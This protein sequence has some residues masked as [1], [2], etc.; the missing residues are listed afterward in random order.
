MS[1]E[2]ECKKMTNEECKSCEYCCSAYAQ[3]GYKFLTCKFPPYKGKWIAEIS[4]CP[5]LLKGVQMERIR[6]IEL[7]HQA[8]D[9][10][11]N[12]PMIDFTATLAD[13]LLDNGVIV[14]PVKVGDTVYEI[15]RRR[16]LRQRKVVEILIAE[17]PS[18]VVGGDIYS[19]ERYH[20]SLF[21]KTVFLTQEEAEASL[22]KLKNGDTP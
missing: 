16:G 7:I 2:Q 1:R 12:A 14:P 13:Y 15:V 18:F 4:D 11:Q 20:F 5:K 3:D 21:G 19:E 9:A 10:A 6:L 8:G 17:E 22:E